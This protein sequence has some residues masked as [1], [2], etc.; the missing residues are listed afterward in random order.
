MMTLYWY[1][2]QQM[3]IPF[4]EHHR[5]TM[6]TK[7]SLLL[8]YWQ[9]PRYAVAVKKD[10]IY[11]RIIVRGVLVLWVCNLIILFFHLMVYI[12]G[13]KKIAW[14]G[15]RSFF[16]EV[17]D[18]FFFGTFLFLLLLR[19]ISL[20][21][22]KRKRK[23]KVWIREGYGRKWGCANKEKNFFFR[24]LSLSLFLLSLSLSSASKYPQK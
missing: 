15:V 14:F 5:Y 12:S 21:K 23:K 13:G 8:S 3:L 17:N 9:V 11:K 18:V 6:T 4:V 10:K 16:V 7:E 2:R 24:S 19:V 1:Y 20:N 22:E